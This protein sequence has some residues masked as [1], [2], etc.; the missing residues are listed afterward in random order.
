MTQGVAEARLAAAEAATAAGDTEAAIALAA[1]AV[2]D[3]AALALRVA[4]LQARLERPTIA[5]AL[6]CRALGGPADAALAALGIQVA[7]YLHMTGATAAATAVLR[8]CWRGRPDRATTALFLAAGLTSFRQGMQDGADLALLVELVACACRDIGAPLETDIV[9]LARLVEE[10]G[11]DDLLYAIGAAVR[12]SGSRALAERLTRPGMTMTQSL[13]GLAHLATHRPARAAIALA[14]A[15]AALPADVSTRFN[16]GYAALAAGDA[17]RAMALLGALPAAGEAMLAGA[18]WPRFGEL[19]WPFTAPPE[20]ARQDFAALLPQGAQWPRIRLVTPCLNPG[21]WLE[22]TILSVAAQGYPAVE[23]VIVDGGSTDGTAAVLARHRD[24]LHSVIV[25]PDGGPAEAINK[26]FAGSDAELLGWINADDVLAPGALHVLGATFA[27]SSTADLVHGWSVPHRARCITGVQMPLADGVQDFTIEGLADIFGRWGAGR[28]FLQPEALIARRF[29]ERL[30]GRLD[31]SLSAVFDYELWLRA[32]RAGARIAQARWPVAFYR[33]HAAQRSGQRGA[34][35]VEQAMVRDRF[36][37]PAP[38]PERAGLIR[39]ALCE[40][41]RPQG[42]P[43]R[44]MLIDARCAETIGAAAAA[45]A[46]EALLAR[47]V[48]LEIRPR[49]AG[50]PVEADLVLRMLDAH[51]GTAWVDRLRA[52]G[53]EGPVVGWFREDDEDAASHA[54]MARALDIVVPARA[55]R[56]GVVL[57]DAALVMEALAPPC[58]LVSAA[59]A[60]TAFAGGGGPGP[61]HDEMWQP[62]TLRLAAALRED[63]PMPV[64]DPAALV[65][66]LLAGRPP[67]FERQ[68]LAELLLGPGPEDRAGRHALGLELLLAP[69]LL[70]VLARLEAVAGGVVRPEEGRCPSPDPSPPKA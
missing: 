9:E 20:A 56:R 31:A 17:A 50:G 66:A 54:A 38:P 30:G 64:A 7:G 19:P 47:G 67:A 23:H 70:W 2:T 26:G 44:L 61:V 39:A 27:R 68:G 3:D 32:A 57:Q 11:R 28:F 8:L 40:A 63:G 60:R 65:L 52:A 15:Q 29:W 13:P 1:E 10:A 49:L 12:D 37:A 43:A 5:A 62:G 55:R 16:A 42:R 51:D 6:A 22:E 46:R 45:E 53:F 48:A 59:Q 58:G 34:L 69:R 33:T 18:A 21:P 36:A 25:E 14:D 41:L 4:L 35:A 24:R